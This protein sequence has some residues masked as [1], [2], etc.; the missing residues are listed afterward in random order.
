MLV[1]SNI[2]LLGFVLVEDCAVSS[3]RLFRDVGVFIVDNI[4]SRLRNAE[5][6][7]DGSSLLC[8]LADEAADE[9][10]LAQKVCDTLI[11]KMAELVDER[12]RWRN[13]ASYFEAAIVNDYL[14]GGVP[15]GSVWL[16]EAL[17]DYRKTV[18]KVSDEVTR[19]DDPNVEVD[20]S[21]E[22][23][24]LREEN[25][26]LRQALWDCAIITGEDT[27]GNSSP[28]SLTHPDIDVFAYRAV[29]QLREDYDMLLGESEAE[30]LRLSALLEEIIPFLLRDVECALRMG[31]EPAGHEDDDC[32]DC[33]WYKD[34]IVWKQRI[35]SGELGDV[36]IG[37]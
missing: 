12:N 4:V 31:P 25:E 10:E 34:A 9:I 6:T 33:R 21:D 28:C 15:P 8:D 29:R 13:V 2:G 23:E 16:L 27:D 3:L 7:R 32:E 36:V 26:R 24:R 30:N 37:G 14:D 17:E 1:E 22:I 11:A 18:D 20:A 35:D 19:I 5:A